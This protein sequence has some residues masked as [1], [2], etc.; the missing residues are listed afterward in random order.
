MVQMH[1]GHL[2]V[3]NIC[4]RLRLLNA[5]GQ[6]VVAASEN[7]FSMILEMSRSGLVF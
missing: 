5:K 1:Q 4:Y 3:A 2:A 6:P 7:Q